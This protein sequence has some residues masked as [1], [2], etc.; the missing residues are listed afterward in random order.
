MHLEGMSDDG[1][2]REMMAPIAIHCFAAVSRDRIIWIS[3]RDLPRRDRFDA[4][5]SEDE[6]DDVPGSIYLDRY[7]GEWYRCLTAELVRHRYREDDR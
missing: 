6:F 7:D 3:D 4:V 1:A 2:G 5:I